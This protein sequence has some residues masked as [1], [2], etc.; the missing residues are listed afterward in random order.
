[1]S[2]RSATALSQ[3]FCRLF[4]ALGKARY[5]FAH[6]LRGRSKQSLLLANFASVPGRD[7]HTDHPA[8]SGQH[9]G[10]CNLANKTVLSST[11]L[12]VE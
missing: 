8:R 6:L 10:R 2:Q 5:H 3:E 7:L 4:S 12:T 11:L 1:M 9:A